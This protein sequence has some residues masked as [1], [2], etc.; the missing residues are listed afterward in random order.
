[1]F[2]YLLTSLT[3]I[4]APAA[5]VLSLLHKQLDILPKSSGNHLVSVTADP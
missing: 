3:L 1:M 2:T 4:S 5:D